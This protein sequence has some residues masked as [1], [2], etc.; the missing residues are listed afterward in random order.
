MVVPDEKFQKLV[1]KVV[2][3]DGTKQPNLYFLNKYKSLIE[4]LNSKEISLS[5]Q[6]E[7]MEE[8]IKE[9]E[10]FDSFQLNYENYRRYVKKLKGVPSSKKKGI[11]NTNT[12]LHNNCSTLQTNQPESLGSQQGDNE[13]KDCRTK[14]KFFKQSFE[15]IAKQ[16][17]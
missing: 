17:Q 9:E 8:H 7:I 11:G 3:Q 6:K 10:K 12:V 5:K 16:V 13:K 1:D 14:S 2:T 4:W 15:D